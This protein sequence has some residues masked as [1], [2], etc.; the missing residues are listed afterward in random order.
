MVVAVVTK[1]APVAVVEVLSDVPLAVSSA[2]PLVSP[3]CGTAV[4]HGA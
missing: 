1:K 3:D 4:A 2:E